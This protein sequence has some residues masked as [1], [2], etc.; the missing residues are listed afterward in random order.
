MGPAVVAVAILALV[1][2]VAWGKVHPFLAFILVSASLRMTVW[3]ATK[4]KASARRDGVLSAT[5]SAR[6]GLRLRPRSFANS[7]F[8]FTFSASRSAFVTRTMAGELN[9]NWK[10]LAETIENLVRK[11]LFA[12][13]NP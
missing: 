10:K 12:F 13:I 4:P 5:I 8:S 2:L 3:A 9:L 11:V 1:L 7:A 6:R